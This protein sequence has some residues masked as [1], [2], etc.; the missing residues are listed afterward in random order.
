MQPLPQ[1]D[2]NRWPRALHLLYWRMAEAPICP[3]WSALHHVARLQRCVN[4]NGSGDSI[5]ALSETP[6]E[7]WWE[8]RYTL[9]QQQVG[10]VAVL[11]LRGYWPKL[12]SADR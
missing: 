11:E 3:Q 1:T 7:Q 8:G 2:R 5:Q 9:R 12:I 4:A 10:P 6:E